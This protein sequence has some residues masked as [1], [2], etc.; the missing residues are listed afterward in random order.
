MEKQRQNE[1]ESGVIQEFVGWICKN[2]A[3]SVVSTRVNPKSYKHAYTLVS[4]SCSIFLSLKPLT[5]SLAP[6][7]PNPKT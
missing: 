6:L 4:I 7:L 2:P 1:M 5:L 3:G